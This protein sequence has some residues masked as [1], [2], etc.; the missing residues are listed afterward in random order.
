MDIT[1]ICM[2]KKTNSF[3]YER[4]KHLF[5]LKK[6]VTVLN[7]EKEKH[8]TEYNTNSENW[9]VLYRSKIFNNISSYKQILK[10]LEIV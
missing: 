6:E 8:F 10:L 4:A 1:F 7:D 2:W 9:F 5:K 3:A